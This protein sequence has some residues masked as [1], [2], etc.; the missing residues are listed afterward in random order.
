MIPTGMGI[1]LLLEDAAR[2][3]ER[4]TTDFYKR[5]ATLGHHNFFQYSFTCLAYKHKSG[6]RIG[7]EE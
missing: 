3:T 6:G 1:L 5:E 4:I 2:R 7:V